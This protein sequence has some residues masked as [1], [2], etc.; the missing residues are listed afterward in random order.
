MSLKRDLST[1]NSSFKDVK[2]G[3]LT[4]A[5]ILLTITNTLYILY[6]EG[7]Y[8]SCVE[9]TM[10]SSIVFFSA[11]SRVVTIARLNLYYRVLFSY[12]TL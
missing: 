6:R 12:V 5:R 10:L 9:V 3:S 8:A 4:S 7:A 2:I 1:S 11:S